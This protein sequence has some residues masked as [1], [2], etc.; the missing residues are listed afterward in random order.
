MIP[1]RLGLRTL[2]AALLAATALVV[3]PRDARADLGE[4]ID[5]TITAHSQPVLDLSDPLDP[6]LAV[7]W[8][9]RAAVALCPI[10]T[11]GAWLAEVH[12]T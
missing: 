11:T 2:L 12:R 4:S 7:D 8:G 1:V 9:L 10:P 6:A 3:L 5:V